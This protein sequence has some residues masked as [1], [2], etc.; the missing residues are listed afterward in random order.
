MKDITNEIVESLLDKNE[1]HYKISSYKMPPGKLFPYKEGE[2]YKSQQIRE[3]DMN[4]PELFGQNEDKITRLYQ[5][6][7]KNYHITTD[8]KHHL[9]N[10]IRKSALAKNIKT[11]ITLDSLADHLDLFYIDC[12]LKQ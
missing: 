11:I 3:I 9:N 12:S 7:N 1:H 10:R 6:D 2:E 8:S 4:P 5:D